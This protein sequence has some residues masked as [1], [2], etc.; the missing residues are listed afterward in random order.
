LLPVKDNYAI[1]TSAGWQDPLNY[2]RDGEIDMVEAVG[3]YPG[4]I[5]SSAQSYT[6]N[7]TNN[8]ERVQ[9]TTIPDYS[10]AFHDYSMDWTPTSLSFAVDG[11]IYHTVTKQP[12]DSTL[13]WPYNEP[14]YL[15]LNIAMGGVSGG[16]DAAQY[17]PDGIDDASAPWQMFVKSISFT[18]YN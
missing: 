3:S 2:L 9:T 18:P 4:V 13:V 17:P 1:N 7:P 11:K 10:T 6:Y 5:S 14:Y 12:S 8:N 16:T 15:I